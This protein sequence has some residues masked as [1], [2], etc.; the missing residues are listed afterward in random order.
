MR[1]RHLHLPA[2][3]GHALAAFALFDCQKSIRHHTGHQR[4][5]PK[6]HPHKKDNEFAG[7]LHHLQSNLLRRSPQSHE[8]HGQL[9]ILTGENINACDRHHKRRL[10]GKAP[11]SPIVS[12]WE[13]REHLESTDQ[14]VEAQGQP[15]FAG[16]RSGVIVVVI[17]SL[18]LFATGKSHAA[19][20]P[21]APP[22]SATLTITYELVEPVKEVA[23]TGN[24]PAGLES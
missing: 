20:M 19:G 15:A 16:A 12:L 1:C 14:A 18:M 8:H 11:R 17:G 9:L 6:G 21:K 24:N 2:L 3:A 4:G 13:T 7:P 5:R 10:F 23:S 22:Q